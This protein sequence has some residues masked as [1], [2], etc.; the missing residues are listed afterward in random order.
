MTLIIASILAA[1]IIAFIFVVLINVI[2]FIAIIKLLAIIADALLFLAYVFYMPVLSI[3]NSIT[4]NLVK[5]IF[6]VRPSVAMVVVFI[7][8]KESSFRITLIIFM[9]RVIL[10]QYPVYYFHLSDLK[11]RRSSYYCK[12]CKVISNIIYFSLD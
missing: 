7:A 6:M 2:I 4:F 12:N 10:P 1:L 9:V 3:S 8:I 11:L 5:S